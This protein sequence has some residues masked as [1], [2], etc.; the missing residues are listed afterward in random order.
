MS[1]RKG[2]AS[3]PAGAPIEWKWT[4]G[5]GPALQIFQ[6]DSYANLLLAAT[7]S[8]IK[9]DFDAITIRQKNGT[10]YRMEASQSG[11]GL[12]HVHECKG[13]HLMQSKLYNLVLKKQA[14]AIYPGLTDIQWAQIV[15][16]TGAEG[17]KLKAGT[18]DDNAMVTAIGVAIATALGEAAPAGMVLLCSK[19]ARDINA[20]GEQCYQ[21]QFTYTHKITL[22]DRTFGST[23]V[24][25]LFDNINRTFTESELRTAE[26]IPLLFPL[27]Q[28]V[29]NP[30]AP[31]VWLKG[32]TQISLTSQQRRELVTEYLAADVW[33]DL[34]YEAKT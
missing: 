18:E 28:S 20:Q 22:P 26:D 30:A 19:V 12:V 15:N 23:P 4:R 27:P 16:A 14:V 10:W 1:Q 24:A 17:A 7:T 34:Y 5:Q 6:E 8:P 2:D 9:D 3:I 21:S 25:G 11:D 29:S 31:S 33:S 13:S 32:A